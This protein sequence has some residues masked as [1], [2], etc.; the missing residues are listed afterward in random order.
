MLSRVR[1]VLLGSLLLLG[2]LPAGGAFAEDAF[3]LALSWQPGFCADHAAASECR[4]GA[5]EAPRF[6]LHGLWPD[7]DVNGDGRRNAADAFCIADESRRRS[8]IARDDGDWLKLPP[9]GLSPASGSDLRRTMP[10][11][12]MGLERH[13][14]WKHGTCSGLSAE[15]YFATSIAL[16]RELERS[17]LARL[18]VDHAGRRVERKRLLDAFEQDFGLRSARALRLDCAGGALQ[19]IRIRLKRASIAQGLTARNLAIPAQAPRGGGCGTSIRI[20]DWP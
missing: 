15:D 19:E 3:L 12:A 9:V 5:G 1:R 16:T 8:I 2:W 18:V 17:A 20:P 7:W 11:V 13:E 6:T 14:W 4:I 10:G